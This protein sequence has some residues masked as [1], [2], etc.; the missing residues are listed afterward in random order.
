MMEEVS[1]SMPEEHEG[2]QIR[3]DPSLTPRSVSILVILASDQSNA[4]S[5][6]VYQ[7]N[8]DK[9]KQLTSHSAIGVA[10]PNCDMVNFTEYVPD[11]WRL[12]YSL[13]N[14]SLII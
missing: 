5:I 2:L 8:L 12:L 9:V 14:R 3:Y 4:R 6:L 1:Y 13:R 7:T 11:L 10:G